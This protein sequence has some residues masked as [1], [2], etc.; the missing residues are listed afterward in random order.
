MLRRQ[1]RQEMTTDAQPEMVQM[2]AT[3]VDRWIGV[4]LGGQQFKEPF[5]TNDIRRFV[6]GM[7]N[8]NPLFY[9]GEFA[10]ER[11]FG[12]IVAPHSFFGGGAGPGATPSIQGTVP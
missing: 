1:R 7:Q 4:P 12:R 5:S 9:N 11:V 6:Q 2:D 3:D 10:A 8:A